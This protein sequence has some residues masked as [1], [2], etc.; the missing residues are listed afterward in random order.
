MKFLYLSLIAL[1]LFSLNSQAQFKQLINK[2]KEKAIEA[3]TGESTQ[4]DS[5]KQPVVKTT[6]TKTVSASPSGNAEGQDKE[7]APG[8]DQTASAPAEIVFPHTGETVK[9]THAYIAPVIDGDIEKI[10]ATPAGQ[11]GLSL[12]R[13]KGFTGS[14]VEVFK[15]LLDPENQELTEEISEEVSDKFPRAGQDGSSGKPEAGKANPAW[16]GISAP[17]LYFE[18]M[19]GRFEL[20]M[21]NRYIK[22]TMTHDHATMAQAFGVNLV[23]ITD[24]AK[25]V[26]YSI[27]ALLGVN[28]TTVKRLDTGTA[29]RGYGANRVVPLIKEQYLG[30]RGVKTEPG[31]GGKFGDYNT[32]SEKLIIPVQPYIDKDTHVKENS[33]LALHDILSNRDDAAAND[34]K[35]H[36]DP[37]YQ[38]IYEYYF[39]HDFD[40]YLPE[41][42]KEMV[43]ATMATKGMCVGAAIEDEHGNRAV[44]RI[45]DVTTNQDV[46]RGQFEVPSD[47]PVM[48]QEELNKAIRKKMGGQLLRGMIRNQGNSNQD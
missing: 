18:Y 32:S 2:A 4:T 14:D 26:S 8:N 30:I 17:S 45:T 5:R 12:A 38:I 21:T 7:N 28:F 34:G 29:A 43:S 27:G 20:W 16:G 42:I 9:A 23:T 46:D 37:S 1:L 24:L 47:Y 33:L 41:G 11:Y 44:F 19:V 35:G 36:Y 40:Q 3:V 22:T 6:D 15:R 48:T 13:Q 25:K 31:Q 39:T 10:V